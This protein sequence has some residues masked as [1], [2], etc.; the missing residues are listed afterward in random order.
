MSVKFLNQSNDC[1]RIKFL[2]LQGWMWFCLGNKYIFPTNKTLK[3]SNTAHWCGV[4]P[5]WGT[6][7]LYHRPGKALPFYSIFLL[8][9]CSRTAF[10]SL[11]LTPKHK[12]LKRHHTSSWYLSIDGSFNFCLEKTLDHTD[13]LKKWL[14]SRWMSKCAFDGLF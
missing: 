14:S 1:H 4:S 11:N 10:C 7:A 5:P 13:R 6:G 9:C 3:L 8:T 12:S 2:K